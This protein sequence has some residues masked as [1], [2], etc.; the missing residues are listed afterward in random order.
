M[1]FRYAVK[2]G[3]P[4]VVLRTEPNIPA[5]QWMIEAID[6]FPQFDVFRYNALEELINNVPLVRSFHY[7]SLSS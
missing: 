5:P 4:F 7:S 3:K 6:G 1:E 2:R